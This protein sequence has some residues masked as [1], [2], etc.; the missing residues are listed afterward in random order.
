MNQ[1]TTVEKLIKLYNE[2]QKP[3]SIAFAAIISIIGLIYYT[4]V[5]YLPEQEE[6]AQSDMYM[7]QFQF[8]QGNYEL[9]LK[10][11]GKNKGF[12]YIKDNYSF[13]NAKKIAKLYAG[14]CKLNL[15]QYDKAI[16]D[17]KEYSTDVTEMQAVAYSSLAGAYSEKKNMK[18]ALEYYE[19]AANATK[20]P[21][22]APKMILLAGKAFMSQKNN[23]KA[24]E[25][26]DKIETDFP[27]SQ[28]AQMAQIYRT[29][30]EAT[31]TK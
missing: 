19:K 23:E 25:M 5:I 8:D 15:G 24:L 7:A 3:L 13:T 16:E 28:E 31:T 27:N 17:L 20:N 10:G 9:A 4:V 12:D 6:A 14:I 22:L 21:A 2:K 30:A 26:F 29:G 1:N 11:E 18:E